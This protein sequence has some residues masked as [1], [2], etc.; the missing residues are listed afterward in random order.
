MPRKSDV[1]LARESICPQAG[2]RASR[3]TQ[4]RAAGF[5]VSDSMVERRTKTVVYWTCSVAG[6]EHKS[7]QTAKRCVERESRRVRAPG[8]RQ[9]RRRELFIAFLDGKS[10]ADAGAQCGLSKTQA[11]SRID[12]MRRL[13]T[14]QARA[15]IDPKEWPVGED[16]SGGR[17]R[18]V[19]MRE[20]RDFWLEMLRLYE[21][22]MPS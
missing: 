7:E 3:E 20:H 9:E 8:Y 1:R 4:S 6:H 5:C 10:V 22:G 18:F 16:M 17:R 21:A 12:Q 14:W 15:H 13:C 11:R 19:A 2:A